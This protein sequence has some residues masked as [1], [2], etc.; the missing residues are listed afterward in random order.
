[1]PGRAQTISVILSLIAVTVRLA[2]LRRQ[3]NCE[4]VP[5]PVFKIRLTAITYIYSCT[6]VL[7]SMS[8]L[9]LN[10]NIVAVYFRK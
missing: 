3:A 6:T 8:N 7:N 1:M 5:H 4:D 10:N 2:A 9:I